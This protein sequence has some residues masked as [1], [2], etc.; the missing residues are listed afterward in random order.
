MGW[1][2]FKELMIHHGWPVVYTAF[3]VGTAGA[4]GG[5]W[6][7]SER[8]T[9]MK[10]QVARKEREIKDSEKREL[11]TAGQLQLAVKREA[12]LGPLAERV[13]ILTKELSDARGQI[14]KTRDDL[15][16]AQAKLESAK[17]ATL[18]A[19]ADL[20]TEKKKTKQ[21]GRQSLPITPPPLPPRPPESANVLVKYLYSNGFACKGDISAKL[22]VAVGFV[23]SQFEALNTSRLIAGSSSC[24][25]L[26][27]AGRAYAEDNGL[28]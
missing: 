15:K 2:D 20:D 25:S 18:K 13:P 12:E 28:N 7:A 6:W 14:E 16:E 24:V 27:S 22:S 26:N 21:N 4:T 3:I 23:E 10:D 8:V 9:D 17:Q 19:Q 11:L 5:L 1:K